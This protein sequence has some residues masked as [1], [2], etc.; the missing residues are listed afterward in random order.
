MDE[1]AEGKLMQQ[2]EQCLQGITDIKGH[3]GEI[4]E[5]SAK[6]DTE[7]AVAKVAIK[8]LDKEIGSL[9]KVNW[10]IGCAFL[11]AIIG[12]VAKLILK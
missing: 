6:S 2:M 10:A 11:L 1:Q 8:G 9:Q 7:I 5:K 12:A 4:Y 3:I